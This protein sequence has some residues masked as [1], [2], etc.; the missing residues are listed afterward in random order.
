MS[1]RP[2]LLGLVLAGACT[3]PPRQQPPAPAPARERELVRVELAAPGL[4]AAEIELQAVAPL[5]RAL[6]GLPGLKALYARADDGVAELALDWPAPDL[7]AARVALDAARRELSPAFGAPVLRHGVE[8]PAVVLRLALDRPPPEFP[9]GPF[10]QLPGVARVEVCGEFDTMVAVELDVQRLAGVPLDR[11][12]DA[13]RVPVRSPEELGAL[14]IPGAGRR[15]SDLAQISVRPRPT[16]CHDHTGDGAATLL[17]FPQRGVDPAQLA[18]GFRDLG[19]AQGPRA[20]ISVIPAEG[21]PAP[22][23]LDLE[24]EPGDDALPALTACLGAAPRVRAWALFGPE[25]PADRPAHLRLAVAAAAPQLAGKTLQAAWPI[26]PVREALAACSPVRRVSIVA[27]AADADHALSLRI[28]GPDPEGLAALAESA[29]GAVSGVPGVTWARV[30]APRERPVR[31]LR[32]GGAA[33]LAGVL[34]LAA[35]PLEVGAVGDSP[36]V[37]DLLPRTGTIELTI[38]QLSVSEGDQVVPLAGLVRAEAGREWAPR[39]RVDRQSA[40]LVELRLRRASDR[41]AVQA[42][43]SRAVPL[44]TGVRVELGDAAPW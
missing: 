2:W 16:P 13:L 18:A 34:R 1:F 12:L 43:L 30:F 5:E 28:L 8:L 15:V 33:R 20:R 41:D 14:E 25:R 17:V 31:E 37:V 21:E 40:A 4:P 6:A 29:L 23:L 9:L 39:F 11:V 35:G 26:E 10:L 44:P 19:L 3:A 27:P 38:A 36:L 32:G 24:L 22:A 7:E 42:A